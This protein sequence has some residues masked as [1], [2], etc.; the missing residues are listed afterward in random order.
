MT[1]IGSKASFAGDREKQRRA[2]FRTLHGHATI[3][4]LALKQP[5]VVAFWSGARRETLTSWWSNDR[6]EV[7]INKIKLI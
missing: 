1:R 7:Q 3:F 4:R 5:S 6:T 2:K